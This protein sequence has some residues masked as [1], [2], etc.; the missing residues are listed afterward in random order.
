MERDLLSTPGWVVTL[1]LRA[2]MEDNR[3]LLQSFAEAKG[4]RKGIWS[5]YPTVVSR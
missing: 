1:Y 5:P 3:A 2:Y 4:K